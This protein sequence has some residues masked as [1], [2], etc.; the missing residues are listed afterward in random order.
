MKLVNGWK[1]ESLVV[2]GH[3]SPGPVVWP[4]SSTPSYSVSTPWM[5]T[6]MARTSHRTTGE[7]LATCTLARPAD[8]CTD[9]LTALTSSST[10]TGALTQVTP[11]LPTNCRPQELTGWWPPSGGTMLGEVTEPGSGHSQVGRVQQCGALHRTERLPGGCPQVTVILSSSQ[12]FPFNNM[13]PSL[14]HLG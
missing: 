1:E 2:W 13:W 6:T 5:I 7:L 4:V 3:F 11:A 9:R 12:L 10:G 8:R 14:N